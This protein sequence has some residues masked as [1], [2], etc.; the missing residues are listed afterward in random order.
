MKKAI[1][2]ILLLGIFLFNPNCTASAGMFLRSKT[3]VKQGHISQNN[4]KEIVQVFQRQ[5]EFAKKYDIEGLKTVYSKDFINSDGFDRDVYFSLIDETWKTYPDITYK[6]KINK[7]NID[8]NYATVTTSET[9]VATT[10]KNIAAGAIYGELIASSDCIYYLKKVGDEWLISSEQ[11]LRETSALKFGDARYVKMTFD[12]PKMVG[13]GTVYTSTVKVHAPNNLVVVGS[14][15][16]SGIVNPVEEPDE[17]FRPFSDELTLTRIFTAN[18]NNLNEYNVAS[19]AIAN[20]DTTSDGNVKMYL[21]GL[22]FVMTR[23]NVIP[24]NNFAKVKD[25]NEQEIQ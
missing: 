13:A 18:E 17:K 1:C 10:S 4:Y 22:A 11:V 24:K 20:A 16:Q 21:N 2:T 14:L 8:G 25:K 12:T 15:D 6:T 3:G 5:D 9:A 19:V 23:V 7:I